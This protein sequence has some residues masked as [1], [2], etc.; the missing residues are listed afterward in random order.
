MQAPRKLPPAR[1]GDVQREAWFACFTTPKLKLSF[2]DSLVTVLLSLPMC[3]VASGEGRLPHRILS[4]QKNWLRRPNI[5][6]EHISSSA[7]FTLDP[8]L[9]VLDLPLLCV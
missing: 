8:Q 3:G 5:T 4:S 7:I 9:K 6:R 1:R 2:R